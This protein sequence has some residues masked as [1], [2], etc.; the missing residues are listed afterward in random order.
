MSDD[1]LR[2]QARRCTVGGSHEEETMHL[3]HQVRAGR[4]SLQELHIAG[5]LGSV[6]AISAMSEIDPNWKPADLV[7]RLRECSP[8]ANPSASTAESFD[9]E[10][11]VAVRIGLAACRALRKDEHLK[12]RTHEVVFRL[13]GN[14]LET[15]TPWVQDP[16]CTSLE[17][18]ECLEANLGE[19]I[20]QQEQATSYVSACLLKSV[21]YLLNEVISAIEI[22][23]LEFL[24]GWQTAADAVA[25][26]THLI[27]LHHVRREVVNSVAPWYL[28]RACESS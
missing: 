11:K 12:A 21:R 5:S 25:C 27:G 16:S 23:D 24:E 14:A 7:R 22:G 18:P 8:Y 4:V 2:D 15:I 9:L 28:R 3:R 19:A 20:A 10:G 13:F 17:A 1:R 26:A 6:L